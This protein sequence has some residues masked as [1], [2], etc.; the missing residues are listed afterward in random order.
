MEHDRTAPPEPPHGNADSD[1]IT[2]RVGAELKRRIQAAAACENRT[3]TG[4][5]VNLA[6]T[7][8]RKVE[9]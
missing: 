9:N 2:F 3:T 6:L 8:L 4:W 7:Q 5:L 1:F